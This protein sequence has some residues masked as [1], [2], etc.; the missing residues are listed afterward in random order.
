VKLRAATAAWLMLTLVCAGAIAQEN[1][2]APPSDEHRPILRVGG[3][4]PDPVEGN[5]G[6]PAQSPSSGF[7]SAWVMLSLSGV[8]GLIFLLKSISRSIMGRGGRFRS[9][10]QAVKVLGRCFLAPRQQVLLLQV[11]RRI[12]VV[13]DSGGQLQALAQITEADE[14]AALIGEMKSQAAP[15]VVGN[16][17]SALFGRAR[18]SYDAPEI[19][20][21]VAAAPTPANTDLPA[22][23]DG[24]ESTRSAIQDL[25]ERVRGIRDQLER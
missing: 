9:G 12:V 11:G 4:T 5:A 14:V 19:D 2:V 21:S 8:I 10:G 17:F 3:D 7:D 15:L 16:P 6:K 22:A 20:E 13:G 25:T 1:A 24:L 18:D 23:T